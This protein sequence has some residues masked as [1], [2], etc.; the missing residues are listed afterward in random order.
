MGLFI[1]GMFGNAVGRGFPVL[2]NL[3]LVRRAGTGVFVAC[4]GRLVR[5]LEAGCAERTALPWACLLIFSFLTAAFVCIGRV[6]RGEYQPLTTRYTTF[7]TFCRVAGAPCGLHTLEGRV[8]SPA[9][10]KCAPTIGRID[11]DRSIGSLGALIRHLP[12]GSMGELEIRNPPYGGVGNGPLAQPG[13]TSFSGK[14]LRPELEY[15]FLGGQKEIFE[16][17]V[18]I[19]E[20]LGMLNPPRATDLRL[21]KLGQEV[22]TPDHTGECGRRW[23]GARTG[24]GMSRATQSAGTIVRR[25]SFSFAPGTRMENGWRGRRRFLLASLPN[26]SATAR[27]TISNFWEARPPQDAQLGAWE[28]DFPPGVFGPRKGEL[29]RLGRWIFRGG[30]ITIILKAIVSFPSV[31]MIRANHSVNF[32]EPCA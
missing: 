2:D 19:L 14:S 1:V 22:G 12:V 25:I 15:R 16:N 6:W 13:G 3:M 27:D 4:P 28:A 9:R 18:R 7:G 26:I 24:G 17:G 21:S 5:G 20:R 30:V 11:R 10:D 29:S 31:G 32:N 23:T 8:L